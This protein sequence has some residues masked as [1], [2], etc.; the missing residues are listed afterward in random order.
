MPG[1]TG[2]VKI[3]GV[4]AVLDAPCPDCS[5]KGAAFRRQ[6]SGGVNPEVPAKLNAVGANVNA[7]GVGA[8]PGLPVVAQ[9]VGSDLK[10]ADFSGGCRNLSGYL[11]PVPVGFQHSSAAGRER[12]RLFIQRPAEGGIVPAGTGNSRFNKPGLNLELRLNLPKATVDLSLLCRLVLILVV[13]TLITW[14]RNISYV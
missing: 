2:T 3:P 14:C 7:V 13:D 8:A 10:T 11:N 5:G 1:K 9:C 4:T 12:P 6:V